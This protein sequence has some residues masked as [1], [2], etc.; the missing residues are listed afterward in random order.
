MTATKSIE[1]SDGLAVLEAR[2]SLNRL[3]AEARRRRGMTQS[4]LAGLIGAKQSAISMFEAG[5]PDALA[6]E[7]VELM[8]EKLDID[9]KS[10]QTHDSLAGPLTLKYCPI[11][12]CPSN[13]PYVAGGQLCYRPAMVE[14]LVGC[15]THCADCGEVLE[16]RCPNEKCRAGLAEGGFCAQCGTPFVTV[17]ERIQGSLVNWADGHRARIRELRSLGET[18]RRNSR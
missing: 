6:R 17:T 16:D 13:I 3:L 18:R 10:A 14:A 5:Q 15:P 1:P 4:E 9:I 12:G 8:A 11:D 2:R 7:K